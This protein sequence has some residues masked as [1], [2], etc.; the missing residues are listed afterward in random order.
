MKYLQENG[1]N[2]YYYV[3]KLHEYLNLPEFV[4]K[5]RSLNR[6]G[7]VRGML[8]EIE[9]ILP[10]DKFKELFYEKLETSPAFLY[11]IERMRGDEFKNILK[12]LLANE[13]FQELIQLA[14]D[15]GVDVNWISEILK[16]IF[17]WDFP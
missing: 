6:L 16:K 7:G 3:K 4:P 9:A 14:K 17:G 5:L 8:D 15:N 12:Q 2:V 10:S 11:L 13:E 1:L